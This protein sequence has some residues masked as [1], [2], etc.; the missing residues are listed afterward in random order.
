MNKLGMLQVIKI[1]FWVQ[2]YK[3]NDLLKK[4]QLFFRVSCRKLF[5]ES[6]TY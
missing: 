3:K 2:R 6:I 5:L 4:V 1:T